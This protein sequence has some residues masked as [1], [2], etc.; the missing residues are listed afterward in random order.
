MLLA[1]PAAPTATAASSHHQPGDFRPRP[2]GAGRGKR[3]L[4][5]RAAGRV[6][7]RPCE[8]RCRV[9]PVYL[10]LSAKS[11][12]GISVVIGGSLGTALNPTDVPTCA[13]P[14]SPSEV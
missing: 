1:R 11:Q 9:L 6:D 4:S 3:Q 13:D 7:Y 2:S 12:T 5:S 8:E 14:T 10:G